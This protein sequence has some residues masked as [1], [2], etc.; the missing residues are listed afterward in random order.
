[1]RSCAKIEA[2]LIQI[3][4][5]KQQLKAFLFKDNDMIEHVYLADPDTTSLIAFFMSRRSL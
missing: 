3:K 1:M 4:K 2:E 5:F